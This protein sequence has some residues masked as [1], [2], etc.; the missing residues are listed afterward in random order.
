MTR[1]HEFETRITYGEGVLTRLA[2]TRATSLRAETETFRARHAALA[3]AVRAAPVAAPAATA[4]PP[5][6]LIEVALAWDGALRRLS[7]R[8]RTVL[9]A[10][11]ERHRAIFGGPTGEKSRRR[12]TPK[13]KTKPK[14]TPKTRTRTRTRTRT[15]T[16]TRPKEP[17]EGPAAPPRAT[18]EEAKA[19]ASSKG[20]SKAKA[21][22]KG[23]RTSSAA[24]RQPPKRAA[25]APARP[26]RANERR[27]E[28]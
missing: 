16:T 8:A 15:T 11:P 17:A 28:G 20:N 22:K 13:T 10:E 7:D 12:A 21:P 5:P 25:R 18:T 4:T 26:G 2:D 3:S 1:A 19:N 24:S 14:T 23:A 9:A 27:P 6:A